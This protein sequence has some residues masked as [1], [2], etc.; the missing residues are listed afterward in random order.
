MNLNKTPRLQARAERAARRKRKRSKTGQGTNAPNPAAPNEST[1]I[2]SLGDYTGQGPSGGGAGGGSGNTG[3]DAAK[4]NDTVAPPLDMSNLGTSTPSRSVWGDVPGA[5]YADYVQDPSL[6]AVKWMENM[7]IDANR[8]GGM[9]AI[10]DDLANLAPQLFTLTQQGGQAGDEGA[11][12]G[13]YLD[14]VDEF[15][16]TYGRSADAGGG[17]FRPDMVGDILF[18]GEGYNPD[19]PLGYSLNNPEMSAAEQINNLLGFSSAGLSA[20]MPGNIAS[21]IMQQMNYEAKKWQANQDPLNPSGTLT[22][23]MKGTGVGNYF[24]G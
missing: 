23:Y 1:P 14:F 17:A 13:S 18:G 2:T 20:T 4:G 24:K 3:W 15:L 5:L 6:A 11:G 21:A 16:N 19:S 9:A 10:F 8:S 22:D 12:F 7:G